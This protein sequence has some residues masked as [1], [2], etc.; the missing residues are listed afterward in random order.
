MKE[1]IFIITIIMLLGMLIYISI[2][3]TKATNLAE[4]YE[5]KYDNLIISYEKH[6]KESR[7]MQKTYA[8][9]VVLYDDKSEI[10]DETIEYQSKEIKSLESKLESLTEKYVDLIN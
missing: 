4:M 3:L 9:Q 2:T 10:D 7:E 6:F 5:R 1:V 8:K